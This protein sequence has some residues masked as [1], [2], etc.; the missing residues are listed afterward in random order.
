MS[1]GS[2]GAMT[3][4]AQGGLPNELRVL[5]KVITTATNKN[6]LPPTMTVNRRPIL[7]L[8]FGRGER[9]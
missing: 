5:L 7:L 3:D 9:I 2:G 4:Q 1:V 6:G 8:K